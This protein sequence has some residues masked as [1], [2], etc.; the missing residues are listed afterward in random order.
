[1]DLEPGEE[2]TQ[3]VAFCL[4]IVGALDPDN[5]GVDPVS[6]NGAAIAGRTPLA[7]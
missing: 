5:T 3:R 1:M 4:G 2:L 7:M 6:A